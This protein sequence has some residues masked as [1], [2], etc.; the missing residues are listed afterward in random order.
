M[1]RDHVE[2][3]DQPPYYKVGGFES[4]DII[5]AKLTREEYIG[6]CKGNILKYT[7]RANYKGQH[8]TD[9]GKVRYYATE[10]ELA[11]Q[12]IDTPVSWP[13]EK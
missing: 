9:C 7:M 10:L 13:N 5:K 2:L 12:E 11:C 6:Y 4:I 1:S 8:N 3:V